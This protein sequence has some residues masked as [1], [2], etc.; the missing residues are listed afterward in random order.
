MTDVSLDI[1]RAWPW[2]AGVLA[3]CLLPLYSEGQTSTEADQTIFDLDV[4]PGALIRELPVEKGDLQGSTYLYD[5]WLPAYVRLK[6]G[7]IIRNFPV[8]LDVH[9]R[10]LEVKGPDMVRVCAFDRIGALDLKQPSSGD[11]LHF[12]PTGDYAAGGDAAQEGLFRVLYSGRTMVVAHPYTEIIKATYV[13]TVDVGSKSDKLVMHNDYYFIDAGGRYWPVSKRAGKNM[14]YFG[15]RSDQLEEF[16][17]ENKLKF[18]QEE[19]LVRIF[20]YFDSLL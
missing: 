14:A 17:K 20:R 13:P 7:S 10:M 11:T 19:D 5:E 2:I 15:D 18:S 4:N 3:S 12:L 9:N 8:K 16:I 6:N 1:R